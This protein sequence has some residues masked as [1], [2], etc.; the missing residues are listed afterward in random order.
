VI[1]TDSDSPLCLS[2]GSPATPCSRPVQGDAAAINRSGPPLASCSTPWRPG[3]GLPRSLL[4]ALSE[5][6]DA[7]SE[8]KAT[9]TWDCHAGVTRPW[10]DHAAELGFPPI[11]TLAGAFAAWLHAPAGARDRGYSQTKTRRNAIT[12]LS[13]LVRDDSPTLDHRV[14][15]IRSIVKRG[16]RYR[17]GRPRPVLR[18][19]IRLVRSLSPP[20]TPPRGSLVLI[21]RGRRTGPSPSTSRRREIAT[22]AHTAVLHDAVLRC[23]DTRK[24]GLRDIAHY[25]DAVD[26]DS[27]SGSSDPRP[28]PSL[29]VRRPRCR[30]PR[31]QSRASRPVRRPCSPRWARASA[32]SPPRAC[33]TRRSC[34]WRIA[35]LPPLPRMPPIPTRCPRGR[36]ISGR[37]PGLVSCEPWPPRPLTPL[38]RRAGLWEPLKADLD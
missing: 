35:C 4:D 36:R 2:G 22:A 31:Q 14:A 34:L 13:D 27:T 7:L 17:R 6:L 15:L 30:P 12:A 28:A 37:W 20:G 16:G 8:S 10:F 24:G 29:W 21:R 19:D 26:N 32:G 33:R 38:L 25:P 3:S 23:D 18:A 9:L 11:P 1:R 5:L